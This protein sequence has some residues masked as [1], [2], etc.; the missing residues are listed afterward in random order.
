MKSRKSLQEKVAH[1]LFM[2]RKEIHQKFFLQ[3]TP[4]QIIFFILGCQRSGT[5]LMQR[6]FRKDLNT[7]IYGEM[8]KLSSQDTVKQL[9][10]NP[11][12]VVKAELDK[13]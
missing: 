13:T 8:S 12:P 3:P 6:V 11:L 1:K 7:R 4:N 2:M 10:L 9:R 5:S